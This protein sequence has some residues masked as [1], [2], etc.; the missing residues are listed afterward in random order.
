VLTNVTI[1]DNLAAGIITYLAEG[2]VF[3]DSI[4]ALNVLSDRFDT[5]IIGTGTRSSPNMVCDHVNMGDGFGGPTPADMFCDGPGNFSA[6]PRFVSGPDGDHYLSQTAAGQAQD[7]TSV[8]AGSRQA[9]ASPVAGGTTRTDGVAD[10]GTVDIGYHSPPPPPPGSV[11]ELGGSLRVGGAA[12][13]SASDTGPTLTLTGAPGSVTAARIFRGDLDTLPTEYTHSAP[14]SGQAGNPEC[15][16]SAGTAFTDTAAL[17]DGRNYYY[18]AAAWAAGTGT[19]G[20]LGEDSQGT[21]RPRPDDS[22]TDRV[23]DGCP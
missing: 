22:P 6:N 15:S 1:A 7:S 13:G 20:G 2:T 12:G 18:V 21:L 8:D 10:A 9:S 14:F 19:L 4:V 16:W 11:D 3:R 23:T 17:G 5:E